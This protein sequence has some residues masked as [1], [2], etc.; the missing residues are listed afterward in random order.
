[1]PQLFLTELVGIKR[2]HFNITCYIGQYREAR[3][4]WPVD[5]PP[6]DRDTRPHPSQSSRPS[7]P[8]IDQVTC[9]VIHKTELSYFIIQLQ[10]RAAMLPFSSLC[11]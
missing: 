9:D 6:R 7:T 3:I 11:N 10:N 1:M 4:V 5:E 2:I 8:E